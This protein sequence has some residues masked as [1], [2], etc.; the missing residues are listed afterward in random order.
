M[1][2][3]YSV[4]C[5]WMNCLFC[6]IKCKCHKI[7]RSTQYRGKLKNDSQTRYRKTSDGFFKWLSSIF[8]VVMVMVALTFSM[9]AQAAAYCEFQN[10]ADWHCEKLL[11]I[12]FT[13]NISQTV[14]LKIRVMSNPLEVYK[15]GRNALGIFRFLS[16]Q[17]S[18]ERIIHYKDFTWEWTMYCVRSNTNKMHVCASGGRMEKG[19]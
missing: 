12:T 9:F 13:K 17:S 6:F 8:M 15:E 7:N 1:C 4:H 14:D 19:A 2:T 16:L 3:L 10:G 11:S 5:A 18:L